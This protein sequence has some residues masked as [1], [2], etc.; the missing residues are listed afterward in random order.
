MGLKWFCDASKKEVFMAPTYDVVKDDKGV[1]VMVPVKTQDSAGDT[2]T[3]MQPKVSYHKPKAY[4]IR[5][6][7]GDETI[8]KVL[9]EEELNKIK[10]K[11]KEAWNILEGI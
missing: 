10:H 7:V 5:L 9:C 1:P 3:V 2:V 11:L 8:Q 4:M 6:S